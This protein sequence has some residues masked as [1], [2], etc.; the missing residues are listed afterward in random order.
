MR[1]SSLISQKTCEKRQVENAPTSSEIEQIRWAMNLCY[2]E[3]NNI[4]DQH[5]FRLSPRQTELLLDAQ[6]SLKGTLKIFF[7]NVKMFFY[8]INSKLFGKIYFS[9]LLSELEQHLPSSAIKLHRTFGVTKPQH[10][11]L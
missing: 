8:E 6:I 7:E 5:S 3:I 10:F 1:T 9:S 11:L 4:V 2:N